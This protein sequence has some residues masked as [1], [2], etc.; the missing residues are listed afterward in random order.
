MK[1]ILIIED[2]ILIL[3]SLEIIF[4]SKGFE[5]DTTTLGKEGL[6]L[7]L[8]NDYELILSDLMLNDLSGF[9]VLEGSLKKYTRKEISNKFVLM[10]AYHSEQIIERAKSYNTPFISKP[11]QNIQ[12]TSEEIIMLI[13]NES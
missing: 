7:I 11:F 6:D 4:K 9:D 1:K 3:K 8:K 2:E 10:S 13:D 12:K 5:V